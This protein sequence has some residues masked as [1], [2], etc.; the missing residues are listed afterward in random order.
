MWSADGHYL[1]LGG[2]LGMLLL[3][4]ESGDLVA[5]VDRE[6]GESFQCV[7]LSNDN[8]FALGGMKDNP[9]LLWRLEGG[10]AE[11]L[12]QDN[13]ESVSISPVEALGASGHQD[14]TVQLWDL[15]TG[16]QRHGLIGH[17]G[18]VQ[19]VAF[20]PQGDFV[21]SG[22][23]DRTIR[24]WD[25]QSGKEVCRFTGHSGP[26]T[27]VA[28]SPDGRLVLSDSFDNTGRI[29]DVSSGRDACRFTGHRK[30]LATTS[31][32]RDCSFGVSGFRDGTI[33]VWKVSAV[34]PTLPAEATA[35]PPTALPL[36]S[37]VINSV[38]PPK[39]ERQ[40]GD[41][42][43]NSLGMKFAW[44]PPGTFLMG[45]PTSEAERSDDEDGDE[46]QHKVT[47]TKGFYMGVHP[48]TQEQWQA[49]MG[50]NPSWES[51]E[52]DEKNLP[53]E[54]VSWN[55]CQ[56]FIKAL[57]N[58]DNKPYRLPTESEWEYS[59]RAETATP[60]YCG[61]TISTDQANYKGSETYGTGKP[62]SSPGKTTPV[63]SFS[64]NAW[65][66]HDM[67]G[68]VS[69][70]CQDWIGDYPQDDVVDPQ[71]PRTG[72]FR[73]VRGGSWDN[74]PGQCRSASRMGYKPGDTFHDSGDFGIRI[75]FCLDDEKRE[76]HRPESLQHA[77]DRRRMG[78]GEKE[79]RQVKEESDA[80]P[81]KIPPKLRAFLRKLE[82][83]TDPTFILQDKSITDEWVVALAAS[84]HL[85]KLKHLNLTYGSV[86][87]VGAAALATSPYLAKLNKL[88]LYNNQIGDE[89]AI[90][91]ASSASIANLVEL[92]LD[93]NGIGD[94]GAMAFL[95]S[96]FLSKSVR[97]TLK[98]N[99]IGDAAMEALLD[100]FSNVELV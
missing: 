87:A 17:S 96:S 58:K 36:S 72:K 74:H 70:W 3:E 12:S 20:S 15:R 54:M 42:I 82:T 76:H 32:S 45:S 40:P 31:F 41:I 13:A 56:A 55:D 52:R 4:A 92:N 94:K 78:T 9:L 85:E 5:D 27:T 26:I 67:H 11:Y 25:I 28:F 100:A 6:K 18:R 83:Q 75:C 14:G 66:L 95:N 38:S 10:K 24:L 86:T 84:P 47:L 65:G 62:G 43:T 50:T 2:E 48:V 21:V 16:K 37:A 39:T 35:T 73:V 69:E 64:A 81:A 98:G 91:I 8:R 63:G 60:F 44:I 93:S 88:A 89:G 23:E 80:I 57:R 99:K 77:E 71:G 22:G 1:L 53:V 61:A 7:A 49:V 29:W 51:V 30:L 46:S 90:A 34:L 79:Q 97:L 33:L 59:C 68:N 19:T